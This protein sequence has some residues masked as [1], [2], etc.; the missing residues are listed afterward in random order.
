MEDLPLIFDA[1][2]GKCQTRNE[3]NDTGHAHG[4]GKSWLER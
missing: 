1:N 3:E 2:D 4:R